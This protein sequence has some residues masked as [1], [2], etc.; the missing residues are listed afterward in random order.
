MSDN[1]GN[2]DQV[3]AMFNEVDPKAEA[4]TAISHLLKIL[5]D[6]KK[7]RELVWTAINCHEKERMEPAIE[8][9]MSPGHYY[10]HCCNRE[11]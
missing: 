10:E 2:L 4:K 1:Q 9:M 8:A 5:F 6:D 3:M 11:D 7:H